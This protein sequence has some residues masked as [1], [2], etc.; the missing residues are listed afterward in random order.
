MIKSKLIE[1]LEDSG[2]SKDDINE[3]ML[4]LNMSQTD[5]LSKLKSDVED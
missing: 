3:L 1:L 5:I 2:Y 4:L